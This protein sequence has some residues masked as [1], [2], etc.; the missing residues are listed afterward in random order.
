MLLRQERE[1]S[2][3][4]NRSRSRLTTSNRSREQTDSQHRSYLASSVS[5]SSARSGRN[6]PPS[7]G[8]HFYN[9]NVSESLDAKI[10]SH[11]IFELCGSARN[12]SHS[13]RAQPEPSLHSQSKTEQTPPSIYNIISTES[14][15]L[16]DPSSSLM[17]S[18]SRSTLLLPMTSSPLLDVHQPLVSPDAVTNQASLDGLAGLYA[19]L[20]TGQPIYIST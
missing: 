8:T 12:S 4:K 11:S 20:I 16:D 9:S 10:S 5:S 13:A 7:F 15:D 6:S 3:Q 2:K 17:V 19:I 1:K 14:Q 18:T